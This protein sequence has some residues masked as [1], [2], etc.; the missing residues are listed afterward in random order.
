M[1]RAQAHGGSSPSASAAL[2][3]K[4]RA[5][6]RGAHFVLTEGAGKNAGEAGSRLSW[7]V[8]ADVHVPYQ[9]LPPV[10]RGAGSPPPALNSTSTVQ[11]SN[12]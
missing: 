5:A 12:T 1:R 4:P 8:D 6:S 3:F 2:R 7:S 9:I 11:R 10:A